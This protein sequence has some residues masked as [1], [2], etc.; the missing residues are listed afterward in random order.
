MKIILTSTANI[1]TSPYIPYF[2]Q[3]N[4]IVS[5]QPEGTIFDTSKVVKGT[6]VA[7]EDS[8][9]ELTVGGYIWSG[10]AKEYKE[11]QA[12]VA[13]L[14]QRDTRWSNQQLGRSPYTIGTHGCL[15][16]AIASGVNLTPTQVDDILTRSGGFTPEGWVIWAKLF[17]VP[18]IKL[19]VTD[20]GSPFLAYDD[21]RA[22]QA[23][24]DGKLVL[25]E[26]EAKPIGGPPSGTH[27]VRLIGGGK[28][29]DPY[30]GD[31]AN[32]SRYTKQYSM[33]IIELI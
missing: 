25:C 5:K 32:F 16:T 10:N 20:N 1:R 8:W 21:A 17:K 29:M 4:N 19:V 22:K 12:P 30:H 11:P 31:I 26:V 18:K 3:G 27:W 7:G 15:I 9:H 28:I 6:T 2:W 13:A 14:S 23:I 33:R 24:K